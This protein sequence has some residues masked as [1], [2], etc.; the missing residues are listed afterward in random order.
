MAALGQH[1]SDMKM[2]QYVRAMLTSIQAARV[3]LTRDQ[4]A[5]SAI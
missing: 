4:A 5:T 3:F 1:G 2:R